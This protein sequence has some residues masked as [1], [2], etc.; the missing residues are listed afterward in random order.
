MAGRL[1]D[2]D[3]T[4]GHP[5]GDPHRDG[6]PADDRLADAACTGGHPVG[7]RHR[8]DRPADDRLADAVCTAGHLAGEAYR[9][10][11]PADGH[12]ADA[13]YRDGR[14]ADDRS[15]VDPQPGESRRRLPLPL[16]FQQIAAHCRIVIQQ[17]LVAP[18]PQAFYRQPELWQVPHEILARAQVFLSA[19]EPRQIPSILHRQTPHLLRQVWLQTQS[20][21]QRTQSRQARCQICLCC[22][23]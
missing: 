3:C 23:Q 20:T 5:A 7:G 17:R 13:G 4:V 14:S 19:D 16:A 22:L 10:G 9:G 2:A 21:G 12:P 6:R 11:R 8:A 1:V 15:V 18:F